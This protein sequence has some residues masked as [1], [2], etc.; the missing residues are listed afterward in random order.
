MSETKLTG[1]ENL[2]KYDL[3]LCPAG[4]TDMLNE[5]TKYKNKLLF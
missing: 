1:R 2:L 5:V 4:P 3:W